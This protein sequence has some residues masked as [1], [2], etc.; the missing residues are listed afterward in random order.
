MNNIFIRPKGEICLKKHWNTAVCLL[1]AASVLFALAGCGN[2]EEPTAFS[3]YSYVSDDTS[4]PQESTSAGKEDSFAV[5]TSW[6]KNFAAEYKYFDKSVSDDTVTI[7]ETR[8]ET[9]FAA[10][11]P[12]TGNLI[13][14]AA[15]GSDIDCYTV[16]PA[17][18]QFMHTVVKNKSIGDISTTLMK[19]TEVSEELPQR[20]NV[21]YIGE[22]T[23]SGRACK[24]YI[25]RAY[26]DG[27]VTE[28]V[29]VWVDAA[30][31]FALK[32][33]DYDASD[34]LKTYWEVTSFAAGN[35]TPADIGVD[36][37]GYTF[38]EG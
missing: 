37:S 2:T 33:E 27:A 11:Y 35:V 10:V 38:T 4:A 9:A 36:I 20:A 30:Y 31:G 32:C 15:N 28:T 14:Y 5:D 19:L 12:E 21:L 17:Q 23:V 26:T 25:Q 24:K 8:C 13:Y 34:A 22:E 6:Q 18:K 7:R 16:A 3:D 1:L 29:Y